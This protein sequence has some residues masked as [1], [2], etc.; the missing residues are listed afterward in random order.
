MSG[1]IT[2]DFP[3]NI[4]VMHDDTPKIMPDATAVARLGFMSANVNVTVSVTNA[5]DSG[6]KG[7]IA[8]SRVIAAKI[9][10]PKVAYSTTDL[11]LFFIFCSFAELPCS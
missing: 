9:N 3:K 1:L 10:A 6:R 11:V 8:R 5:A 7:V 4:A 2:E